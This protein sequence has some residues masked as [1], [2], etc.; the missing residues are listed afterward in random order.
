MQKMDFGADGKV[1]KKIQDRFKELRPDASFFLYAV[2]DEDT[3]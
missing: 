2:D 1:A 3:K